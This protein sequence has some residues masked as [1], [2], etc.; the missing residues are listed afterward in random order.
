MICFSNSWAVL[1][2]R[3]T[4]IQLR[5]AAADRLRGIREGASE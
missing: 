4:S 2:D 5:L 3:A 1:P